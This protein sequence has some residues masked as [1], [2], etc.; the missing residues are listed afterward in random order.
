M[1]QPRHSTRLALRLLFRDWKAG[2]LT[3]LATALLVGIFIGTYSSIYVA[4]A[5]VLRMGVSKADLMP[6]EKEGA[7][8]DDLP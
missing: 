1:S 3:V 2:E 4:S 8:I 7:N 5:L 6:I